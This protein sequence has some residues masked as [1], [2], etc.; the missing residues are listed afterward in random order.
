MRW[1]WVGLLGWLVV[2]APAQAAMDCSDEQVTGRVTLLTNSGAPAPGTFANPWIN[3]H[4]VY[5]GEISRKG[6]PVGFHFRAEGKDPRTGP[7]NNNPAAARISGQIKPQQGAKGWRIYRGEGIEIWDGRRESYRRKK[8]FST[9]FPNNCT[10]A[11]VLA[12]IR[13]AVLNASKPLPAKGGRFRGYSG[14]RGEPQ[15]YCYRREREDG[16]GKAFRISGYLNNLRDGGW[17]INT[18]YPD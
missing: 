2:S 3:R 13:H 5:C 18:A 11:E 4:H 9:F 6:K 17:T 7:G 12:S 15:G 16:P 8:G 10:P 14:P 1:L